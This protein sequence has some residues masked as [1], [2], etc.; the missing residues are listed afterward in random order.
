MEQLGCLLLGLT[1]A[2]PGALLIRAVVAGIGESHGDA[3]DNDVAKISAAL[4]ACRPN[5]IDEYFGSGSAARI[6][7]PA[8]SLSIAELSNLLGGAGPPSRVRFDSE[9]GYRLRL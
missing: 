7:S 1:L 9:G 4:P 5:A 3:L 2:I 8:Q 6:A